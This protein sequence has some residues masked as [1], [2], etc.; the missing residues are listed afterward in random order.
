MKKFFEGLL[1]WKRA[2]A[3]MFSASVVICAVIV[4]FTGETSIQIS[5]LASL[6][7]VSAGGTFLQQLAFTDY[8]IKEMRYPARM[9]VFL[10][11]FAILLMANVWFF[12]WLPIES[13]VHWLMFSGIFLVVFVGG[14]ISFEIYYR[15]MGKKYD[16]LLGQYHKQRE[17]TVYK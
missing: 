15:A 9:V 16:G 3:L 17:Q 14:T 11:P 13:T 8:I 5:V 4:L 7:V 10:I 6:L 1:E 12:R 2:T